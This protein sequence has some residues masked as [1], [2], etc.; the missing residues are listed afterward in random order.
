[1]KQTKDNVLH[2]LQVKDNYKHGSRKAT[3]VLGYKYSK[4]Y[5]Y[6]YFEMLTSI[7]LLVLVSMVPMVSVM[8]G[9]DCIMSGTVH[10][11]YCQSYYMLQK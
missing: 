10:E 6:K 5:I 7:L 9:T 3:L 4:Q 1:M 2:D 11:K 8:P